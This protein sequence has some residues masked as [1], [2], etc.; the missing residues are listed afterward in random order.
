MLFV[1]PKLSARAHRAV[2]QD[3]ARYAAA[4]STE[5]DVLSVLRSDR[6]F[7]EADTCAA[8]GGPPSASHPSNLCRPGAPL[9]TPLNTQRHPP[10]HTRHTTLCRA[11]TRRGPEGPRCRG[12]EAPRH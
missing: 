4:E 9:H 6:P 8:Q 12:A 3:A 5:D 2:R 7:L 10:L 1:A 11:T